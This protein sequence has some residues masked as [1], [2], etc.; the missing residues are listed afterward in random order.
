MKAA[1]YNRPVEILL[2][3]DNP[4][5]ARLLRE[6]LQELPVPTQLHRVA[7]GVAALAFLRREGPY[8]DAVRPDLIVLDLNL[9][10]KPGLEVLAEISADLGLRRI[11]LI[12]LSGSQDE[13]DIAQSYELCAN[14]YVCKPT[15]FEDFV[16]IIQLL[17]D[18]WLTAAR[19]P[20]VAVGA[21]G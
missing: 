16:R 12:V 14:C 21:A 15:E 19:L 13:Q 6:A 8:A 11:P 17:E 9:P 1:V 4:G 10:K 7:D 2:V 3:E 18:F 5:D 20:S